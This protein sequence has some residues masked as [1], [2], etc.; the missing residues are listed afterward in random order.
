MSSKPIGIKIFGRLL[1]VNCPQEQLDA[2]H[3]AAE[4]LDNRLHELKKRTGVNNAEQLVFI[5][6]LNICHELEQERQNNEINRQS[7]ETR[8]QY[9][10]E[11]MEKALPE[12]NIQTEHKGILFEQN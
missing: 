12:Q 7:M 4:D 5:V 10:L 8:I 11:S 2:L 1:K 6:A 9:L 3:R